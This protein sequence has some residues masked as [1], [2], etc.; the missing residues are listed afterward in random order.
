MTVLDHQPGTQEFSPV[1][2]PAL[3]ERVGIVKLKIAPRG[4]LAVTHKRPPCASMIER[5]IDSPM[6]KPSAFVV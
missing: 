1:T 3:S 5:Q 6:P 2:V 4:W